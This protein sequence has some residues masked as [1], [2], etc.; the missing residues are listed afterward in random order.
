MSKR[1]ANMPGPG[2]S[3]GICAVCGNTFFKEILLGE[4]V[5]IMGLE[6]LDADFCVHADCKIKLL[7]AMVSHDWHDI[8]EGPLRT[9]FEKASENEKTV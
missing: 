9:I 1:V 5:Q 4:T 8:P 3:L 6:N 2:G 7:P